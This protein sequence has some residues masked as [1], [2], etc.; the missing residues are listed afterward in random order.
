[1]KRALAIGLALGVLVLGASGC[2]KKKLQPGEARLTVSGRVLLTERG[3]DTR[4]VEKATTIHYG[5]R[6]KVVSG[7]ARI[8]VHDGVAY[9]LRCGVIGCA[10]SSDFRLASDPTLEGGDV[11]V[12]TKQAPV[13][14]HAAGSEVEV[15]GAARVDRS[16]AVTA[17]VYQGSA[18]LRSGGRPFTVRALRQATVPAIGVLP[19]AA[20][21]LAY[22]DSDEW[23]RRFLGAAMAFG[24]E[25]E[26][27]GRAFGPN[28]RPGEG[29]TAGFYKQLLPP[30]DDEAAFDTSLLT[31]NRPPGET[32][33]GA[34]IAVVGKTSSFLDRWRA[35]FGFRD[36]GA[37]WGLVALD[38]GVTD[39]PALVSSLDAAIGRAPLRFS[40]PTVVAAGPTT[41]TTTP[42]GGGG[43]AT[44]TTRPSPTTTTTTTTQPPGPGGPV[45]TPTTGTPVDPLV[46]PVVDTLNG[47]LNPLP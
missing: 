15:T 6:V 7:T 26:A 18:V 35:V 46:A 20:S 31:V 12:T 1:M 37:A 43:G 3:K 16:L 29:R 23:D 4:P 40:G 47:L 34:T 30:L 11:L 19:T 14:I 42:S 21:P 44:T 39:G 41:T 28:V 36:E 9:D 8:E 13:L 17:A 24:R 10:E 45:P 5:D 25:L 32:L 2:S 33:V 22:D 27:R 38:Q